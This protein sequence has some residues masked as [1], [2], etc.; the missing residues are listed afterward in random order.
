MRIATR[1]RRP[2]AG[3]RKSR[4]TP[5]Q[6]REILRRMFAGEGVHAVAERFGIW[7][8]SVHRILRETGGLKP[9]LRPRSKLRLSFEERE[10]IS[11]DLKAGLSMRAIAS[12]LG[13]QPSTIS[14]EVRRNRGKCRYR[15]SRSDKKAHLRARRPKAGKLEKLSRLRQAVESMLQKRYSPEQISHIL[16]REHPTDSEMRVSHETIYRSLFVQARGT[17]RK[18]LAQYLR[19]GRT[20]RKPRTRSRSTDRF[21]TMLSIRERPAEVS[22][23]AVPGSWEGDLLV[24]KDQTAIATLVERSSRFVMLVP[25]PEGRDA[26]H[27][28]EALTRRILT[29]PE[30]LRRALTWDRG[31]EMAQHAQFTVDTN[32]QVYFCDP[33]SPWQ[34]GSNE[35]TN[36][37]LRQYFPKGT[38]LSVHTPEDLDR[39]AAELNDRPRQTLDWMRP[40]EFLAQALR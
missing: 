18:E 15:A 7:H 31:V 13:R 36:G 5:L 21:G 35:N 37:L 9:R 34:R 32:V 11:R 33:H 8:L 22:D 3:Q 29:L 20:V 17:F 2:A 25:L 40:S 6:R 26:E 14:R 38:D 16:R 39:V 4:L 1:G 24:G 12:A 10:E 23:R 19:T 30:Q 28:R 27:V